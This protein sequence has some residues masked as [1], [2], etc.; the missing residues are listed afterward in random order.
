MEQTPLFSCVGCSEDYS[1]PA[2]DLRTHKG[3]VWCE[4]C[5]DHVGD[6]E[7]HWGEFDEFIP[8][9]K[10]ELDQLRQ[11]NDEAINQLKIMMNDERSAVKLV[12]QLKAELDLNRVRTNDAIKVCEGYAQNVKKSE[13]EL[14]EAE[15]AVADLMELNDSFTEEVTDANNRAAYHGEEHAKI[16]AERERLREVCENLCCE[17]HDL[18]D[19]E[20]DGGAPDN[21]WED[22]RT[23]LAYAEQALK[24]D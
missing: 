13:A 21:R 24:Q 1:W 4:T 6:T 16:K 3:D 8:E 11:E 12:E 5:W 19:H 10:K 20:I 15:G 7:K 18:S 23:A 2:Q 17:A 9:F 22:M 14:T